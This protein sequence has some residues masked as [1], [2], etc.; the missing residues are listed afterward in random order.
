M[1]VIADERARGIGRERGLAGPREAEEH[2][3]VHRVALGMVGRA[4]HRHDA[5]FRQQV[6]EQGED[7]FLVLA[8]IFGA[9]HKDQLAVEVHRDHRLAAA[10]VPLG[11]GAEAGAVDQREI[12]GEAVERGAL[13]AAQHGA[14]EQ[15][16]PGQF[17]DHAHVDRVLGIGPADEI[18]HEI[19]AVL[20]VGQH[21]GMKRVEARRRHGG[22]VFPPDRVF[23]RGGA[24]DMLV[25]GRAPG[26]LAC[27]DEEGPA[28]AE[29]ALAALE[30]GLDQR[31][32]EQV[33]MHRAQPGDALMLQP[34]IRIDPSDCHPVM[35]LAITA[36][37]GA[38]GKAGAGPAPVGRN[39]RLRPL[40]M[41]VS[42]ND[43]ALS[44]S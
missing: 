34:E 28:K 17:G 10:V 20:H 44:R 27:G 22:V 13:G 3:R 33:V 39:T 9:A 6:V 35:L 38:P 8:R 32:F 21:V 5:L 42:R 43:R 36:R 2:G 26:E 30:R 18:L 29:P 14:V 12:G 23:D 40:N 41:T 7:R 15:A 16:V 19:L 4:M 1:L 37:P 11:V 31:R 24:H 25:P